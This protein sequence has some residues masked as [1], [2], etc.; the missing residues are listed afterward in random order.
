MTFAELQT[1]F[2]ARGFD[3]LNQDA[4]GRT[5]AKRWLNEG[6]LEDICADELWDFLRTT[7]SGVAPLTVSDVDT[8]EVVWNAT[9]DYVLSPTTAGDI[10]FQGVDITTTG[11]AGYWYFTSSTTI[12]VYPTNTS[13]SIQV[14]YYKIPVELSA[15]GDEPIL[16]DRWHSLLVDAAVVRAYWD[17]DNPELGQALEQRFLQRKGRMAAAEN[18]RS[19]EP[20]SIVSYG[21]L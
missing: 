11:T 16:P 10:E 21:D 18:V 2:Y 17:S 1:E 7:A 12:A 15:D 9:Q 14:R 13:D 19:V 4:A 20:T 8:V 5:R 3:Y 6:Y